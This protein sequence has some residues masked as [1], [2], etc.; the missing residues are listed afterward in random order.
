MFPKDDH[1]SGFIKSIITFAILTVVTVGSFGFYLFSN[2]QTLVAQEIS[3][4]SL[5]RLEHARDYLETTTL[6]RYEEVLRDKVVS[7]VFQKYEGLGFFLN[8]ASGNLGYR[9][10]ELQHD[11]QNAKLSQD[12]LSNITVHFVNSGFTVDS[13]YVYEK[14]G[15]SGD[16]AFIGSLQEFPLNHWT[17]RSSGD[18]GRVLTYLRSLPYGASHQ[19]A[20]GYLYLDV[21]PEY[22]ADLLGTMLGSVDER[23]YIVDTDG[24]TLLTNSERTAADL[25]GPEGLAGTAASV[26]IVQEAGLTTVRAY[27]PANLSKYGWGFILTRPLNSL[28]LESKKSQQKLIVA[29]ILAVFVGLSILLLM[30]RRVYVPLKSLIGSLQTLHSR[31]EKTRLLKL[32]HGDSEDAGTNPYAE[33]SRFA[34]AYIRLRSGALQPEMFGSRLIGKP[35]R[36]EAVAVS[37]EELAVLFVLGPDDPA[38]EDTVKAAL[39]S[40]QTELLGVCEFAA[41][42]GGT[43]LRLEHISESFRE[44]KY[45]AKYEFLYGPS[46]VIGY[47]EVAGRSNSTADMSFERFESSVHTQ[48]M[49]AISTYLEWFERT[50]TD[51]DCRIETAE[52]ALMQLSVCLRRMTLHYHLS[53]RMEIPD[54]FQ[55]LRS[56]TLREGLERIEASCRQIIV[57]LNS[58]APHMHAETMNVIQR[59]IHEHLSE[60]I[61]LDRIAELVSFSPSYISKLFVEVLHIPFIEYLNRARLEHAAELLKDGHESVTEIASR[62]GYSNVQYFCTR[63]KA[64]FEMTPNQYRKITRTKAQ[65][66][67]M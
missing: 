9:F 20:A 11:I 67:V 30:S 17:I 26:S 33:H 55:T 49:E 39:Q 47:H 40:L 18:G 31:L 23:F 1:M 27:S 46:A 25:G 42:F 4:D 13:Q 29:S 35:F 64:K 51:S 3:R 56:G 57:C 16:A 21:K 14:I 52:W 54:L 65:A 34:A 41:G 22:V 44:A 43:M 38:A 5:Y 50:L 8:D 59:Y 32:I 12:G 58:D 15:N 7:T 6:K 37:Q 63:F 28:L 19:E 53:D 24:V 62:V 60:D 10:R 61:S 66:E 2:S 36:W 45:A 48:D